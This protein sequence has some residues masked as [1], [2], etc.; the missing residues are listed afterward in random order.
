MESVLPSAS[1]SGLGKVDNSAI[2][3]GVGAKAIN[4]NPQ[5]KYTDEDRYKIE[6]YP[7]DHAP[8]QA[9][10][11]F[12][13]KYSNIKESTLRGYLEKYNEQV[14]IEKTLNQPPAEHITNSTS[15]KWL[16]LL[17]MKSTKILNGTLQKR[18]IY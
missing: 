7:K 10:R 8:N 12:H 3:V 5:S 18:W 1:E 2:C 16:F 11:C 13:S 9:A 17:L 14:R 15:G 6:K 4:G